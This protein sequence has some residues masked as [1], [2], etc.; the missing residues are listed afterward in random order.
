M[1]APA[2][3]LGTSPR[4]LPARSSPGGGCERVARDIHPEVV[5]REAI[6]IAAPSLPPET[7]AGDRRAG[8]SAR[9]R[10]E[11]LARDIRPKAPCEELSR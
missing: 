2:A 8:G 6:R 9:G 11:C 4:S 1:M 5:A 3:P 10:P 7:S